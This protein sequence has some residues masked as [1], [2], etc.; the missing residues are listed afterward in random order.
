[1]HDE[2]RL[3]E[4]F[5]R[6]AYGDVDWSEALDHLGAVFDARVVHLATFDKPRHALRNSFFAGMSRADLQDFESRRLYLSDRNP[7]VEALTMTSVGRCIVDD[8]IISRRDK[9]TAPV[10][11]EVFAPMGI[12]DGMMIRATACPA[13]RHEIALGIMRPQRDDAPWTRERALVERLTVAVAGAANLALRCGE[14]AQDALIAALEHR[15]LASFALHAGGKVSAHSVAAER[16]LRDGTH[17]RLLHGRLAATERDSDRRL[18]DALREAANGV[19]RTVTLRSNHDEV[20][21]LYATIGPVPARS[22]G[23]LSETR[24]LLT[25]PVAAQDREPLHAL[26]MET[27]QLTSSEAIV[28][29]EVA[30]GTAPDAI[31][32]QRG[33]SLSTIRTQ[34]RHAMAKTGVHRQSELAAIIAPMRR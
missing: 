18:S 14:M 16:M 27:F 26:L 2:T 20:A 13:S 11:R 12:D 34:I 9:G 31:A 5:W 10:Y 22:T 29:A 4:L 21:P 23:P 8:D 32:K 3:S 1:M 6:A 19:T 7:R 15:G 24:A 33:V 25:I 17:L 28:A 30:R